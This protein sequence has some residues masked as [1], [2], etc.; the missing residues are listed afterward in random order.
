MGRIVYRVITCRE[1][2]EMPGN[3]PNVR[4]GQGN[5]GGKSCHG[6]LFAASFKVGTT[7]SGLLQAFTYRFTSGRCSFQTA[8]Q[9]R[10]E[11]HAACNNWVTRCLCG[12]L[13]GAGADCLHI[14]PAVATA[15]KPHHLLPRL[16]PA[17]FYLSGTGLR[18]LSCKRQLNWWVA[19]VVVV[20]IIIKGPKRWEREFTRPE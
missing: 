18:R 2:L 7:F 6:K 13:S 1:N 17:W 19:V 4:T 15:S 9:W 3:W 11:E 12:Y 14:G 16:N 8:S 10:Q 5:A 20:V